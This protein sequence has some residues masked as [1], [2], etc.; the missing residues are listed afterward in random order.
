MSLSEKMS[1]KVPVF[2]GFP[3]KIVSKRDS[4]LLSNVRSAAFFI[5]NS[6]FWM[7]Q[8]SQVDITP[9]RNFEMIP[10]VG[11]HIVLLGDGENIVLKFHRLFVFY[12]NV[13][14]KTGFDT[15]KTINVQYEGQVVGVKGNNISKTD[16]SQLRLNV[17][18]LLREA[19]ELQN[20]SLMAAR[21]LQEQRIIKS[22][23]EMAATEQTPAGMDET[24]KAE[25]NANPVLVT[26]PVPM[27]PIL[28]DKPKAVMSKRNE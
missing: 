22:D 8:V 1:A 17:E 9:E 7:A 26:N 28:N 16:T 10:V 3:E 13:L 14:S 2:T 4:L 15:Y 21:Q 24:N 11:N 6:P 25:S 19:R 23:P 27:K 12:K 5:I 18:K 20:D